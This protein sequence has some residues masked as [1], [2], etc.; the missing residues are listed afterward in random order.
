M[1]NAQKIFL[2]GGSA[3][4][5]KVLMEILPSL[6]RD[7]SFP[8][9]IILHRKS[10]SDSS[11]SDL[12]KNKSGLKVIEAEEK[13]KLLPG[14]IYLAP[15]DYHLLIE[16][17]FTISLD[18]SEKLNYSRPSIDITFIS[19]S[20]VYKE[21]TL[22]LLLSGA[23]SDGVQGLISIKEKN[24]TTLVQ[25]PATAEVKYMPLQAISNAKIDYILRPEEIAEYIN[26]LSVY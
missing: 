24:G 25:E 1:I 4:S 13:D 15:P 5:L 17:D 21:N 19:A 26:Q 14:I 6:N 3:G 10:S 11:L 23:N 8:I 12:L 16:N 2:I 9:I 20:E 22:A 7:L 18:F